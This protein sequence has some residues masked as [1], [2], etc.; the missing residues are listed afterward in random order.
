MIEPNPHLYKILR[1][2]VSDTESTLS[3]PINTICDFFPTQTVAQQQF[4]VI[5]CVLVLCSV[6]DLEATIAEVYQLLKPGGRF[7]FLE[8][9]CPPQP[10]LKYSVARLIGP[11]WTSFG[12]GCVLTRQTEDAI[13]QL[14][15]KHVD[16]NRFNK[17][18]K[19]LERL[20]SHGICGHTIK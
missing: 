5:V 17:K 12:D 13:R 6:Q 9:V 8:H 3:Y 11:L 15:W 19:G 20:A 7:I 14:P 18:A 16:I 10:S 2:A 4:D 1:K